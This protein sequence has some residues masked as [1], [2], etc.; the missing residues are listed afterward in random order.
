VL[1]RRRV[2]EPASGVPDYNALVEIVPV[3]AEEASVA[4]VGAGT[5]NG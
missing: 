1:L 3:H 5:S 2:C 4:Q